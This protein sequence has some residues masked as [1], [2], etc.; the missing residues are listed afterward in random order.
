MKVEILDFFAQL[1]KIADV[2]T[3]ELKAVGNSPYS[4]QSFAMTRVIQTW[5]PRWQTMRVHALIQEGSVVSAYVQEE[6]SLIASLVK[7]ALGAVWLLRLSSMHS[8][9]MWLP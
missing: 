4:C 3:P 7:M 8:T 2:I 1:L 5:Q 6:G 9:L